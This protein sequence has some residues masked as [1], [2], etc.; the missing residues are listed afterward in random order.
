MKRS[1]PFANLEEPRPLAY[2]SSFFG[3]RGASPRRARILAPSSCIART[4]QCSCRYQFVSLFRGASVSSSMG[5]NGRFFL[6]L[7]TVRDRCQASPP[8]EFVPSSPKTTGAFKNASSSS[9]SIAS[10]Q[11]LHLDD[12]D[13]FVHAEVEVISASASAHFL[14]LHPPLLQHCHHNHHSFFSNRRS[15]KH[16]VLATSC[17]S[18]LAGACSSIDSRTAGAPT[19]ADHDDARCFFSFL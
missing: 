3:S 10:A 5:W 16:S 11:D 7:A 9:L 17:V 2:A 4:Q 18:S 15:G 12:P 6:F 1:S 14:L 13:S 8:P 19:T